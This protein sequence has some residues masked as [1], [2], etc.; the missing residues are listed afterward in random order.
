MLLREDRR[1]CRL[2]GAAN[3]GNM[4]RGLEAQVVMAGVVGDDEDGP[5]MR[6][7]L[8]RSGSAATWWGP[9]NR[10][11]TVKTRVIGRA[12]H[13]HPHQVLRVDRESREP[14]HGRCRGIDEAL[15]RMISGDE[16][17]V[18]AVLVSDYAKGVCTP[19]CWP[20]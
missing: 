20:L 3:V 17:P 7:Q 13:R 16:R 11:D 2:G 14:L 4:L 5:E 12:Q 6:H 8:S 18:D 15:E 9:T 10:A 19:G 1:E